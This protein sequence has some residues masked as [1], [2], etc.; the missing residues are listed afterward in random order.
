M[1]HYSCN[2]YFFNLKV[3]QCLERRRKIGDV[4]KLIVAKSQLKTISS[5]NSKALLINFVQILFLFLIVG[6]FLH[7]MF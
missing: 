1:L 4:F 7:L 6:T 3:C 2:R 5:T